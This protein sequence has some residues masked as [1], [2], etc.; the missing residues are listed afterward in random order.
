MDLEMSGLDVKKESILE[1]ATILTDS[2]LEII[3][4]G[5][6]LAIHQ[7]EEILQNMDEWNTKHHTESGLI[8][9]V[10]ASKIGLKEAEAQTIDFLQNHIERRKAPLCGNSIHQDRLFLLMYMPEL[11]GFLHYRNID[12]SSIKELVRR[13]YPDDYH[14][15]I[16]RGLHRALDDIRESIDEL[17]HYRRNVFVPPEDNDSFF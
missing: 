15:P 7:P 2:Q 5:P 10:R 9:R 13:W 3:E 4:E 12:V 8:E 14:P 1:I 17:R 6:V 11:E 16:K